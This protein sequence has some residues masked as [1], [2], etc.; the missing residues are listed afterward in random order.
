M[1]ISGDASKGHHDEEARIA[2]LGAAFL[3]SI[4]GKR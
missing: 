3:A 1:D 4:S 2:A